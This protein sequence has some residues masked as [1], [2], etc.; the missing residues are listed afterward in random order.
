MNPWWIGRNKFFSK[1]T[2]VLLSRLCPT[3]MFSLVL[4]FVAIE[5]YRE[6]QWAHELC[7]KVMGRLINKKW[8]L[9]LSQRIIIDTELIL[10]D[11]SHF[12]VVIFWQ[13]VIWVSSWASPVCE[14]LCVWIIFVS[15]FFYSCIIIIIII[16]IIIDSA[17]IVF[18][19]IAFDITHKC[20]SQRFAL[21]FTLLF[22]FCY[23]FF[24][25]TVAVG[26]CV[27]VYYMGDRFQSFDKI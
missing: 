15:S 22:L 16:N 8:S 4:L 7:W 25:F 18:L 14:C 17:R 11:C 24:F 10:S 6:W 23:T 2:R 5:L 21:A 9:N 13:F 1:R 20:L 26:V 19:L 12:C 3:V 27:W